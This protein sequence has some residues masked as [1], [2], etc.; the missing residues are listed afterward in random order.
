MVLVVLDLLRRKHV[1]STLETDLSNIV[2]ARDVVFM[3]N[4]LENLSLQLANIFETISTTK[5]VGNVL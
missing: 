2:A 5:K 4:T 1:Y 3:D